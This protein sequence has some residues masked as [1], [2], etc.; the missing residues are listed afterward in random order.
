LSQQLERLADDGR[1]AVVSIDSFYLDH[2]IANLIRSAKEI[3]DEA[4]LEELDGTEAMENV[5]RAG[6]W[7]ACGAAG[8][9]YL[10][11]ARRRSASES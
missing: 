8:Y 2:L 10:G 7:A 4:L 6:E 9:G 1:E 3:R 5:Y 11:G